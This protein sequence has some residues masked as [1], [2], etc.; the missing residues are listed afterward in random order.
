MRV[1]TQERLANRITSRGRRLTDQRLVVAE[2]LASRK[3][4]ISAQELHQRLRARN[5]RLALA[6]VYRALEAQVESGMARQEAYVLVQRNAM[7]AWKGEGRFRDN[8]AGDADVTQR[9]SAAKLGE[10]FDLDHALAHVPGI[11]ERA[12]TA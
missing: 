7:R 5:P 12:L 9:L 4:A 8:L 10:L 11:V 1:K 3:E 6:T 2:A